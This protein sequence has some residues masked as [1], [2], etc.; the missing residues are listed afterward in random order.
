MT[1]PAVTEVA[2]SSKPPKSGTI[3]LIET[4]AFVGQCNRSRSA[5]E[6]TYPKPPLQTRDCAAYARLEQVEGFAG[7]G[8]TAIAR[9][10]GKALM[11]F[12]RR[13]SNTIE[14]MLLYH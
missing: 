3:C 11:P 14:L 12:K 5:I 2:A 6:E 1:L 10:G 9:D 7:S 4:M 8:E 13:S